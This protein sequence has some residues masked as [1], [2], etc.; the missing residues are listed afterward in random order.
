MRDGSPY[1]RWELQAGAA[2]D[3]P[4]RRIRAPP[5]LSTG[6]SSWSEF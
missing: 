4:H 3:R 5:T 6:T 2:L 1:W